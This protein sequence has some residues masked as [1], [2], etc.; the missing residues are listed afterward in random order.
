LLLNLRDETGG[1]AIALLP[2]TGTATLRQIAELLAI[3]AIDLAE[4]WHRLP[5]DDDTIALRLGL[6]RQQ[7]INLR[8]AARRRLTRR[9]KI[10][11]EP[12][13]VV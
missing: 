7:V 10:Q 9:M 2:H 4:L 6:T 1:N 5:L 12:V 11:A 13:R 8:V 3:P